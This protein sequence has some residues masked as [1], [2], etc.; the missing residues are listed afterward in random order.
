MGHE[1]PHSH[2]GHAHSHAEGANERALWLALGRTGAFLVAE[3]V[4]GVL[5]RSLAL[6]S[7]AAHMFTDT[8]A[9][10]IALAA[11]RIG[12]PAADAKRTFGYYRF[13]IL[14]AAVNA[15]LLFA[16]A[17]YILFEAY[18]RLTSP[19]EIH[20]FGMLLVATVGLCVNFGAMLLLRGGRDSSPRIPAGA[21]KHP[22]PRA[23]P[24]ERSIRRVA[25]STPA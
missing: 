17:V 12:K 21:G 16:V 10:A 20:N 13:E 24:P 9:L 3:V 4:G 2:D 11:I 25:R 6:I 7:D 23:G 22:G 5:T 15:L 1:H 18:T 19:P 8:A 14:A